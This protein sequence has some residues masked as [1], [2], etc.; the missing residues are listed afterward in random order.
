MSVT[1]LRACLAAAALQG[2]G[3]DVSAQDFEFDVADG[4][5]AQ[6]ALARA[7]LET[8]RGRAASTIAASDTV[9]LQQSLHG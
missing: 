5:V 9:D 1:D 7:P 2:L 8:L 3:R 6:R 4:L